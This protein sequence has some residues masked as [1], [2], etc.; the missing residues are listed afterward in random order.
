[1]STD[2]KQF[3][4]LVLSYEE[5]EER[6]GRARALRSEVFARGVERLSAA[7]GS[8]S[9]RLLGRLRTLPRNGENAA[10]R[11]HLDWFPAFP[12]AGVRDHGG[13]RCK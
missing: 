10:R 5:I 3:S 2:N 11:Q 9:R 13:A 4:R 6:I 8:G 1:M 12:A 7:V